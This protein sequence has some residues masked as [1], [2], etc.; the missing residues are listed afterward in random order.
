MGRGKISV[1]FRVV[2]SERGVGI[3]YGK[4]FDTDDCRRA[5]PDCLGGRIH[6]G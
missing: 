3:H 2:F 4:Q 5:A 6:S 1:R